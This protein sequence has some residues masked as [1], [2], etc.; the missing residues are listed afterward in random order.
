MTVCD[1][2]CT[3]DKGLWCVKGSLGGVEYPLCNKA[4]IDIANE[5]K[6][7]VRSALP[8][9]EAKRPPILPGP[10]GTWSGV[11]GGDQNHPAQLISVLWFHLPT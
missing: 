6:G 4:S 2:L 3:Y 7:K 8:Q 11:G 9:A 5:E 10:V 1:T